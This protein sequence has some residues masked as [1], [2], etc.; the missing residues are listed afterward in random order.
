MCRKGQTSDRIGKNPGARGWVA[1]NKLCGNILGMKLRDKVMWKSRMCAKKALTSI[2]L[3]MKGTVYL[4]EN[5]R[6]EGVHSIVPC[7]CVCTRICVW[8]C[9]CICLCILVCPQYSTACWNGNGADKKLPSHWA[10]AVFST[11]WVRHKSEHFGLIG[12]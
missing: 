1:K 3:T 6:Q 2:A 8:N 5:N 4:N 10:A 11:N 12:G 7:I 9:V